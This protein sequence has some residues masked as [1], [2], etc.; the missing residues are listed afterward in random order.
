M[1]NVMNRCILACG[2][3]FKPA[4]RRA[5]SGCVPTR[6]GLAHISMVSRNVK[7]A[8]L[9]PFTIAVIGWLSSYI[10]TIRLCS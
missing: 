4:A 2:S 10:G 9:I 8:D 1:Q 5:G 7:E 3:M 6:C